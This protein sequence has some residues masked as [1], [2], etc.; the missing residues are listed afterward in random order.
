MQAGV[1]VLIS[2]K[3]DFNTKLLFDREGHYKGKIHQGDTAILNICTPNIRTLTLINE[4]LL[5]LK[6]H[7]LT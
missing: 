4:I 7:N 5:Q 1:A 6:S 3:T 2:D